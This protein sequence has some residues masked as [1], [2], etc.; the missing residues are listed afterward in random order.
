MFPKSYFSNYF[1]NFKIPIDFCVNIY[2]YLCVNKSEV[3]QIENK[4]MGRPTDNPK[5]T[6]LKVR[7]SEED[8]KKLEFCITHSNKNK[9][10]IVREGIDK[11]YKEL[12]K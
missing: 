10:E 3:I 8:N 11:V 2:Y 6:E 5:N 12:K 4:K 7:I 9:S 1:K